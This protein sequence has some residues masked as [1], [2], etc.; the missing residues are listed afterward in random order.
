MERTVRGVVVEEA[1]QALERLAHEG[2]PDHDQAVARAD[3]LREPGRAPVMQLAVPGL[4]NLVVLGVEPGVVGRVAEKGE[5]A[6]ELGRPEPGA[7][8]AL[9]VQPHV[10]RAI[11]MHPVP[12][13]VRRLFEPA[14]EGPDPLGPIRPLPL[15]VRVR[16]AGPGRQAHQRHRHGQRPPHQHA[17]RP[18]PTRERAGRGPGSAGCATPPPRGSAR[19]MGTPAPGSARGWLPS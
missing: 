9:V 7:I 14:A 12:P 13:Q 3:T 2:A 19:P 15:A 18:G 6:I 10:V 5:P 11:V 1:G 17:P 4:E 16:R 8:Q